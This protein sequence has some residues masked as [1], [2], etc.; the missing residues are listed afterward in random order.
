[1]ENGVNLNQVESE[2]SGLLNI[3]VMICERPYRLKVKPEEEERVR[4]AAREISEKV[5]ELQEQFAGKDKQD[6][7]AMAALLIATENHVP[8]HSETV[9]DQSLITEIEQLNMQI[10]KAINS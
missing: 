1:M 8:E 9:E 2:E 7:I 3:Q 4:N 6:F 10:Q 5:K